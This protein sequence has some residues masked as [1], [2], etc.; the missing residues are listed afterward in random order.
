MTTHAE[1]SFRGNSPRSKGPRYSAQLLRRL[2]NEIPID[3]LIAYLKWPHKKRDGR[4][5]FVCPLC[6][7]TLSSTKSSTNLARCFRCAT[8]FNPIDFTMH[9]HKCDFTQAVEFL[10]PLLPP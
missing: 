8:N 5:V 4:F 3:R 6:S 9:V 7:E 10:K 2:R 1:H